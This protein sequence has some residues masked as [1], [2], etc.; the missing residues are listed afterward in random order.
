MQVNE[1]DRPTLRRL[2]ELQ[3]DD[4]CVLS[5]FL[6]LAPSEFATPSARSSEI[7][8]LCDEAERRANEASD[9][10]RDARSALLDDVRRARD[11]LSAA[12]LRRAHGLAVYACG[13]AD[14]F[15]ALRLP[16][17]VDPAV[18]IDNRPFI[19]PIAELVEA[20]GICV[21]LV[22]R[23][24]TRLLR[25]QPGGLAEVGSFQDDVHGRHDQGGWSQARYQRS[26]QEAVDDHLRR[27][28]AA[29]FRHMER[30]PCEQLVI[31]APEELY[32]DVEAR[33]HPYVRDRVVGRIEVDVE[34]SSADDVW[35]AAEPVI[36]EQ[37]RR[38]ERDALDRLAQGVGAGG[39]AAA[40]LD[41]VLSALYERRVEILLYERGLRSEGRACPRCG[42]LASAAERCPVDGTATEPRE[43]VLEDAVEAAI[44]QSAE[45]I[46]VRHHPDLGPLGGIGA[47]LRF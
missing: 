33:L 22:N 34:D 47:V 28:A 1:V 41:E 19:A 18:V 6:S 10:S 4:A 39:A 2:A 20:P 3:P 16:R 5:L 37:S 9:L 43:N 14:L 46:A 8:S 32:P 45:A 30:H 31:G 27:A 26:I 29:L 44:A 11:F 42:W 36:E 7:T 21:A 38:R 25:G 13:P 17:P 24:T 35:R 15:E 23:R 12:D 40:G